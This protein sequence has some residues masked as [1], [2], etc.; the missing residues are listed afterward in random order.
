MVFSTHKRREIGQVAELADA[1]DSK[2]CNR[3]VVRV[4]VPPWPQRKDLKPTVAL[5]LRD[6]A[7]AAGSG[8]EIHQ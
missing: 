8:G 7:A 3:K 5:A 6:E 4:Q 1:Q 2:S